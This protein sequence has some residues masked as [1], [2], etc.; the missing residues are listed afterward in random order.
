MKRQNLIILTGLIVLLPLN[1][2]EKKYPERAPMTPAMTEYWQP[3]PP[4][5][6]PDPVPSDAIVLFDGKN[7]SQW[8]NSKGAP[9]E[10][11]VHN[12]VFTVKKGTGDIQTKQKFSDFQLHLEWCIPE[13]IEG[14]SQARGNSGLFLQG[15]Y[16]IQILD[17]YRNETYVNGQA[18]SIYKQT[19]PLVNAM[20]KPGEWN[21]YDIIYTA[22]TFK[23]D[24]T[25]RTPPTVT[26]L[27]N[28][29]LL[30]NNTII[31]GNTPYVGFPEV[32][33]HGPGPI[34]LQD[35]GDPSQPISFRNIWIREL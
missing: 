6:T 33:E 35:H 30:Q 19:P 32:K 26:L 13:G 27:Q 21:T 34:M 9:A 31:R 8:E 12:G 16:E 29:I 4:V 18:G 2:Q 17:N 5:V 1:A 7:L 24:G 14:E 3:Q 22:P 25:Y 10:W 23:K 11:T 15:I 28:G 20:R